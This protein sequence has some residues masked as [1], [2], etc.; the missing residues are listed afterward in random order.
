LKEGEVSE[1]NGGSFLLQGFVAS[2]AA[3]VAASVS[4][5][6]AQAIDERAWIEASGYFPS[7]DTAVSV[8][9]PGQ[10][11]T[12]IDLEGELGLDDAKALPAVYAGWE[13]GDRWQVSGEFYALDREATRAISR[14]I[15]FDG[16]T[17]TLGTSIRSTLKSDVYRVTLGYAFIQNETVEIGAAIGLHTTDFELGLEGPSGALSRRRDFITPMPTIGIY[18]TYEATDKVIL[19][20]R[21]DYL[22]LD[23]DEFGGGITNVQASIAYRFTR[24]FSAGA[25]YRY[26]SYDLQVHKSDFDADVD[27]EFSGPSLFARL[28]F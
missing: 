11:G 22:S 23:F 19:N 28:G 12:V 26:V 2:A 8:S 14:D 15:V 20:G 25:A 13:F 3:M 21:L 7:I 5:A 18:G 24:D 9:R 27:Y 6:A 16:Q 17:Y 1:H 10:P 4:P